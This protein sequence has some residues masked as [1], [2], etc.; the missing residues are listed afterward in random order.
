M[1]QEKVIEIIKKLLVFATDGGATDSEKS[2]AMSKAQELIEK[3]Q[4]NLTS[5]TSQP[6]Q[7][8]QVTYE[9]PP[10]ISIPRACF[11]K[12]P[13][14]ASAIGGLFGCYVIIKIST[15]EIKLIGFPTNQ[16][17]AKHAIDMVLHQGI[18]DY[19]REFQKH[20][21]IVFSQ[22]FWQGFTEILQARFTSNIKHS[23]EMIIYDPVRAILDGMAQI[24][25]GNYAGNYG[26]AEG[27]K[28][29]NSVQIHRGLEQSSRGNL[30]K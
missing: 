2:T 15:M 26:R 22:G 9:P 20:R 7:I 4:I 6:E 5:E 29:G 12:I 30:L 25:M 3:Y 16:I 21:T 18:F 17:I 28:S 27:I 14:I 10:N 24:Q 23:N 1:E 13:H 19:K 11:E 8:I